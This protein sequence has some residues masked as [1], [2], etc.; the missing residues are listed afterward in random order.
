MKWV[1]KRKAVSAWATLL[2]DLNLVPSSS[3]VLRRFIRSFL[4]ACFFI[5]VS[6]SWIIFWPPRNLSLAM[7]FSFISVTFS[8]LLPFPDALIIL[9]LF[10][11]LKACV[12]I[13]NVLVPCGYFQ[14]VS[15]FILWRPDSQDSPSLGTYPSYSSIFAGLS[16]VIVK[17]WCSAR[18]FAAR[19]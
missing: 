6:V 10:P 11:F 15:R 13:S 17:Y 18:Q 4:R 3:D 7:L 5:S 9:S 19:K 14:A 8:H 16:S 2:F 12:L 1:L